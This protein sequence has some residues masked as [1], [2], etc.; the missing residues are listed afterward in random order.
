MDNELELENYN[1]GHK[2]K[3]S[4]YQYFMPSSINGQ[5]VWKDAKLNQLLQ[6]ASVEL[7][8]LNGYSKIVPDVGLFIKMH[9]Y[10]EAVVSSAIEGTQ[11]SFE[12]AILPESYIKSE[13]RSDWHEVQN[14]VESLQ[15]CLARLPELPLSTRLLKEAHHILM[16]GVRGENKNPGEFRQSQNWIGGA[17]LQDAVFIPPI[18][19]EI[20]ALMS[21]MENFLHNDGIVVPEL[22]RIGIAHWY[23]ETIH[24]F[25]DGNGRVG[26]LLITL[27]LVDKGLT[28]EPLLYLSAFFEQN[29]R[30]YYD[31]L[32]IAREKNGL[33]QWLYFFLVGVKQTAEKSAERLEQILKLKLEVQEK[34]KSLSR[35]YKKAVL[36]LDAIFTKPY[37]SVKDVENITSLS[38]KAAGELV[39]QFVEFG[40]LHQLPISFERNRIFVFSDYMKIFDN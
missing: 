21:E 14:Y 23:F 20:N 8:R 35:T 18:H 4:G 15:H 19:S 29:R 1:P 7:G 30:L 24:P 5:W 9:V 33:M 32:T 27:Y 22:I 34:I 10:K 40:I 36:L 16:Q 25:L 31:N 11:T 39:K 17:S 26:R 2:E 13:R 37:I 6:E 3:I 12:E 28:K 38:P